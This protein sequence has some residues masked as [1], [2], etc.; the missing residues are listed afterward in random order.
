MSGLAT[1]YRTHTCDELRAEHAGGEEAALAGFVDRKVDARSFLIRDRYGKTL[2]EVHAEAF[3]YVEEVVGKLNPED[4]VQVRGEV[5]KRDKPDGDLPTGA[6]VL[7]ARKIEVLCAADPLPDAMAAKEIPFDDRL[8]YRQ[9]YLRRPEVQKRLAFRAQVSAETRKFLLGQSFLEIETP[10]LF[11]YDP[12]AIGSEIVPARPGRAFSLAGGPLVLNHYIK[13]GGF[14][15]YFQFQCITAREEEPTPLHAQEYV[16]L[17]LNMAYVDVPDMCA[18]VEGLLKHL[19]KTTLGYDLETPFRR[20]TYAES[21]KKH[22]T[23]KPDLRADKKKDHEGV[24]ITDYPYFQKNEDQHEL[25]VVV[26]SALADEA[27]TAPLFDEGDKHA[28]R[29]KAFDL[30][31]DGMEVASAYIG[32]HDLPMQRLIWK[33]FLELEHGDLARMR[34]PIE[35][36]RFGAPPHGAMTLGFDRLVAR[37]AGVDAI[38]EVV[39]FPKTAECKDLFIDAPG[40]ITQRAVED[41]IAAPPEG[42]AYDGEEGEA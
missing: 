9:L 15:R 19:Y 22:G 5:A 31:L 41:L 1:E 11:L 3:P 14:D 33:A 26:F 25:G 21:M 35:A 20:L 17:D 18:M 32:N 38:D 30:V 28:S 27:S 29:A 40:P 24:W 13:P 2:V 8:T 16:G 23:D 10:Q 36:F 42:D 37:M 39:A 7:R 12:V 6:V 4:V 34:A